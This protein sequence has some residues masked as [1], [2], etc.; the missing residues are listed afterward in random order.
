[1]SKSKFDSQ[2]RCA[3]ANYKRLRPF[4][5]AVDATPDKHYT[6]HASGFMPLSIERLE[7]ESWEGFPVYSM[8]H[9]YTQNGDT[10]RDPDMTFAVLHEGEKLMPLTFRQDGC[11]FTKYGTLYQEVFPEPGKYIP[12]LLK[13]LDTFLSTWTRNIIS[14]GFR[15]DEPTRPVSLDEFAERYAS[16]E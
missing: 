13:D 5:A 12:S 8:M 1:M 6:F 11:S 2:L 9:Y 7:G 15:P 16:A 10:M 3:A 14:Q 4:I